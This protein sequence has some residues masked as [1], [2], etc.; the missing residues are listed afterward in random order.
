MLTFQ[1]FR[2]L[3]FNPGDKELTH[4]RVRVRKL[5]HLYNTSAPGKGDPLETFDDDDDSDAVMNDFRKDILAKIL[6][7]STCQRDKVAIEPPFQVYVY[8]L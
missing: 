2:G 7:L 4:A 5:M 1:C 3:P 6:P 8:P